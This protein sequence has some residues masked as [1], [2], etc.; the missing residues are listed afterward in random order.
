L[1]PGCKLV[2]TVPGG[3]MNA[4]YKHIG[5]RRHYSPK[6]IGEVLQQAGYR[7]EEL[8]GAGFPFFN[9]FRRFIGW[10]GEKLIKAVS[11]EPS[12]T[13]RFGMMVFDLLFRLNL[14]RWGW[15]TLAVARYPGD[16]GSH[17]SGT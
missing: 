8:Y 14:M 1:A 4:F 10:R 3:P 9:L 6:E 12:L 7:V 5:H 17:P 16:E 13:V 15:Q 11:G 2:V